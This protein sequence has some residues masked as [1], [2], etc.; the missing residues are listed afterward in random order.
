MATRKRKKTKI[1]TDIEVALGILNRYPTLS[2]D[3]VTISGNVSVNPIEV[4]M[5]IFKSTV[6]YNK[7]LNIL[8]KFITYSL[9]AVELSI[10][11][12]L[13]TEFKNIVSCSINPLFNDELLREGIVFNIDEIDISDVLKYSP[14]DKIGKHFYFNNDSLTTNY[15]F[16]KT[17][18]MDAFIWFIKNKANRRYSWK[19]ER[20]RKDGDDVFSKDYANKTTKSDGII[21][22][23]Y[24]EKNDN[25][26]NAEG[27][28]MSIQAPKGDMLHVFIGDARE[29]PQ[30]EEYIKNVNAESELQKCDFDISSITNKEKI[31]EGEIDKKYNSITSLETELSEGRINN[32]EYEEKKNKS[33]KEIRGKEIVI[34]NYRKQIKNLHQKKQS[35]QLKIGNID[36]KSKG[37]S[38]FY[39]LTNQ[40]N[41]RNYYYGKSLLEFNIDYLSS[42]QIF[43]SKTLVAKLIDTLTGALSID[44]GFSYK[45]ALIKEEVKKMI[46]MVVESDDIVVS[47]CFFTFS[48]DDYDNLSRLAEQRKNG[49]YSNNGDKIGFGKINPEDI[50]SRLNEIS[51]SSKKE[52]IQD[53]VE[54]TFKEISKDVSSVNYSYEDQYN[55]N[56]QFNFIEK[57]LNELSYVIVCSV[58]S[59]KIYLL[60]MINL[61]VMGKNTNSDMKQFLSQYKTFVA[62]IVR[63]VRD[64]VL[65]HLVNELMKFLNEIIQQ[66][67]DKLSQEQMKYYKDLIDRLIQCFRDNSRNLNF[68]VDDVNYADIIQE[69]VEQKNNDC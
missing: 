50:L 55:G 59:P 42:L 10:K 22:L 6:G 15:D 4:L 28:R 34:D 33:L 19:P 16:S 38:L 12:V 31:I 46:K 29:N 64:E 44:L 8:A 37:T 21:T 58:L 45:R 39:P 62:T 32:V 52:V 7:L 53:V 57:L 63:S 61:K 51:S 40:L 54:G 30:N 67:A 5:N 23:E 2:D 47:D 35:L 3:D 26:R 41:H 18:D 1:E 14:L 56:I 9:P 69:E 20:N 43:D 17:D 13:L 68:D 49:Y 66:V 24:N 60:M 65:R 25:I 36:L 27:E 48:N 11:S